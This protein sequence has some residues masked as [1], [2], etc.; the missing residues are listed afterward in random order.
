MNSKAAEIF[1][2]NV[3][4]K[5]SKANEIETITK[6]FASKVLFFKSK[7]SRP[8]IYIHYNFE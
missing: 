1:D 7:A 4:R 8:I 6:F 2:V 5:N 3:F